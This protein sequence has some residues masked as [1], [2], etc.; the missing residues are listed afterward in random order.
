MRS[1]PVSRRR[2]LP[3][4]AGM[5]G[6]NHDAVRWQEHLPFADQLRRMRTYYAANVTLDRRV[7]WHGSGDTETA[8]VPG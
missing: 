1:W 7:G 3:T 8:R 5:I 2:R 4:A 6:G